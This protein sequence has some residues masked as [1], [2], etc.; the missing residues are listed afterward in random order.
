MTITKYI[1]S[2]FALL[3]IISCDS[4]SHNTVSKKNV[5]QTL[6][7]KKEQLAHDF[8][9]LRSTLQRPKNGLYQTLFPFQL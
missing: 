7:N 1:I 3:L 9:S 8:E 2:L 6:L 4:D 5:A